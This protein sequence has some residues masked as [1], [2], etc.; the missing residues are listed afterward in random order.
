MLAKSTEHQ[1]AGQTSLKMTKRNVSRGKNLDDTNAQSFDLR[2]IL[3]VPKPKQAKSAWTCFVSERLGQI[4][5]SDDQKHTEMFKI[6]SEEWSKLT[7][8]QKV[9]YE[10]LSE[11]DK[12]R[13]SNQMAEFEKLGYFTMENGQLSHL[14][15]PSNPKFLETVVEPKKPLSSYMF[16]N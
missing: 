13:H 12:M 10:K 15:I 11:Q 4:P 14:T 3:D 1:T 5:K 6:I 16:Y 2:K 7:K 8:D 9:K